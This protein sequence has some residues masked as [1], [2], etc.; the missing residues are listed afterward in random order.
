M[1]IQIISGFLGAGKTTFLNQYLS[2]L[3]GKTAVIENEF[4]DVGLDGELLPGDIPVREINAGCICCTLAVDFLE[5]I[6]EMIEK[7]QPDRI[8]IE[9]S[10]VAKLSEIATACD[11]AKRKI[12]FQISKK[13]TI[14]DVTCC[15][16]YLEDF[17]AF[18][19]DQI[20]CADTLLLSHI[21]EVSEE[22][23][24]QVVC[25]LKKLNKDAF[26]Y[27]DDWRTL[28]SEELL[29]IL[30]QKGKGHVVSA[31]EQQVFLKPI[32]ELANV[33]LEESGAL[34]EEELKELLQGLKAEELGF[35]L[36]AK[37]MVPAADN[38]FWKFDFT[39]TSQTYQKMT[40]V[41]KEI[42]RVIIIG[43]GLKKSNIRNYIYSFGD[44]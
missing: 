5:G 14:V 33:T 15:M 4:G 20:L 43:C 11:R 34:T 8:L 18:Y 37:G 42:N 41:E 9:P 7:F 26:L 22:E 23:K 36:R 28:T 29:Y 39:R 25:R 21:V 6:V 19:L 38:G 24:Q 12:N 44:D 27:E 13:I 10:G 1:E 40:H 32:G 2:G 35:V 16:E 3:R 30:N 17:G 31:D